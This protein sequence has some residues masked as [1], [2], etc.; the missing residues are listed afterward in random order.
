MKKKLLI[1]LLSLFLTGLFSIGQA[2]AASVTWTD[3]STKNQGIMNFG[4]TTV[5]VT[6]EGLANSLISGDSYYNNSSTGYTNVTGTYGGLAPFDIIQEWDAGNVKLTFSQPVTDLYLSL[7]SVGRS[8]MPVSYIFNTPF[9][10]ISS[11]SNVWG[12]DH[13]TTSGN[14]YT[15][16]ESNGILKF[17]GTFTTFEFTIA[18]PEYWHGFNIAATPAPEPS[19]ILLGFLAMTGLL[20]IRKR[21]I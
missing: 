11:G 21:T 4:S 12:Y 17:S 6:L 13:Y 18:N 7:V 10:V 3:W 20:G 14:T 5:N 19:S 8:Y 1:L 15:G 9:T 2:N 16:Y